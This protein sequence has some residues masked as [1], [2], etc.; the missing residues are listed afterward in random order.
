MLSRVFSLLVVLFWMCSMTALFVRDVWPAWTAQELPPAYAPDQIAK[1]GPDQQYGIFIGAG[2][3]IG[4]SWTRFRTIADVNMAEMTHLIERVGD[5][6][7]IRIETDL[8]FSSESQ[9]LEEFSVRLHGAPTLI[10]VEG[11]RIGDEIV[12]TVRSGTTRRAFHVSSAVAGMMG[13][14]LR[15][16]SVLPD[17]RVGQAWRLYVVDPLSLLLGGKVAPKAVLVRVTGKES[18]RHHGEMVE[19]FVVEWPSS[20]SWVNGDGKV[21][22]T[23]LDVPLIGRVSLVGEPFSKD[24]LREARERVPVKQNSA[25]LETRLRGGE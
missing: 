10:V 11:E 12:C 8:K 17:L 4:T 23:E 13:E 22:R 2:G 15:P 9:R 19:A 25:F 6:G 1:I 14:S 16:F 18:I 7:P 20:R 3:R 21:L 5:L 24:S